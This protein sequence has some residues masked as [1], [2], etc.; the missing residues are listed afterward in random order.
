MNA[1]TCSFAAKKMGKGG[2]S[3]SDPALYNG[4]HQCYAIRDHGQVRA[5]A[6]ESPATTTK[7]LQWPGWSTHACRVGGSSGENYHA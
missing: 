4:Y 5:A 3:A 6:Q 2:L 1:H 7:E